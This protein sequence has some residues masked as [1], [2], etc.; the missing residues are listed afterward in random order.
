M[1]Q[2]KRRTI[3]AANDYELRMKLMKWALSRGFTMDVIRQCM[4]I[5]DDESEFLDEDL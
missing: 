5:E 3:R 4:E 2:Q 1:L